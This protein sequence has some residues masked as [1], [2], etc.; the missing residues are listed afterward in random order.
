MLEHPVSTASVSATTIMKIDNYLNLVI[1]IVLLLM[2]LV[3]HFEK[4]NVH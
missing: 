2:A 1:L 4:P 3:R